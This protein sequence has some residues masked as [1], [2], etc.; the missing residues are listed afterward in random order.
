LLWLLFGLL[1]RLLGALQLLLGNNDLRGLWL[2]LDRLWRCFLFG[3]RRC[4]NGFLN[5][6]ALRKDGLE[7]REGDY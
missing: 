6:S 7:R 5:G 1:L 2:L 4:F 3:Y